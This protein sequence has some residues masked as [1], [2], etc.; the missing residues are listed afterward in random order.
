VYQSSCTVANGFANG[1]YSVG[2]YGSDEVNN[3]FQFSGP[4]FTVSGSTAASAP[5]LV[6]AAASTSSATPGAPVVITW[7]IASGAPL[8]SNFIRSYNPNGASISPSNLCTFP[9]M[10]SGTATDGVFQSSCTVND[11]A[12]KGTY[13]VGFY[14]ADDVNNYFQF[15]GPS[16]VISGSSGAA[17]PA[18]RSAPPRVSGPP[19]A[20]PPTATVPTV[21]APSVAAVPTVRV[22]SSAA[23]RVTS[24][25]N[26]A[27][28][29][30]TTVRCAV[31][32]CSIDGTLYELERPVAHASG[33]RGG[34]RERV[35][36]ATGKVALGAG[37]SG[38]LVLKLTALG[39][40]QLAHV[41]AAN[42]VKGLQL[43]VGVKN[44]KSVTE[45]V[46]LK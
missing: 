35:A 16:F 21:G 34:L 14:G 22:P 43:V 3:D 15:S 32:A 40:S 31:R 6:S 30:S 24:T 8:A 11:G 28:S 46:S 25:A 10:V 36:V 17:A 38:H 5:A 9:A 42:P 39:R 19:P 12:A 26:R 44:G 2:F 37:K 4:S 33:Q 18:P 29:V 41:S 20:T 1:T 13:S 27:S 7:E 45:S 23:L